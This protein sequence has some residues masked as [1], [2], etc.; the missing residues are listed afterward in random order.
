MDQF[1]D[2]TTIAARRAVPGPRLLGIRVQVAL[3]CARYERFLVPRYRSFIFLQQCGQKPVY[4]GHQFCGRN[5]AN[6]WQGMYGQIQTSGNSQ[7]QYGQQSWN[8]MP[9]PQMQNSFNNPAP[10]FQGSNQGGDG[11]GGSESLF[12]S[13]FLG[14]SEI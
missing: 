10:P 4:K 5:C 14:I 13:F 8:A 9:P 11:G 12:L 3:L 1:S 7:P 6:A 2:R